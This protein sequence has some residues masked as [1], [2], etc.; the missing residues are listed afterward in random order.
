LS[1][2]FLSSMV[3]AAAITGALNGALMHLLVRG[4][5]IARG[6]GIYVG[7]GNCLSGIGPAAFGH[8]ITRLH[9]EYWGSFLLLALISASGACC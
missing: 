1:A 7:V 8:F 6:T 3:A 5:A 9:G 4:E 2:V